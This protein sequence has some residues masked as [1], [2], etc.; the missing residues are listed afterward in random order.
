M[1]TVNL[2]VPMVLWGS[3]L[4][5]VSPLLSQTVHPPLKDVAILADVSQSVKPDVANGRYDEAREIIADLIN[6]IPFNADSYKAWQVDVSMASP[7]MRDLF[8]KYLTGEGKVQ[9]G[10]LSG[11]DHQLLMLYLGN[12]D[13]VNQSATAHPLGNGNIG[14]LLRES[15]PRRFED[16]STCFWY[17][18]ARAANALKLQAQ[19]GYYLFVISD[20]EDD[21]E[22]RSDGPESLVDPQNKEYKRYLRNVAPNQPVAAI[23]AEI[24]QYFKFD[25]Y[26]GRRAEL[27]HVREGFPQIPIGRIY[28]KGFRPKDEPDRIKITWYA[29]GV[30]PEAVAVAPVVA[31]APPPAPIGHPALLAHIDLLGG[32][33]AGNVSEKQFDYAEPLIVWQVTN[34]ESAGANFS[35]FQL[36]LVDGAQRKV[37]DSV[38]QR[39]LRLGGPKTAQAHLLPGKY[40]LQV[41]Q[42]LNGRPTDLKSSIFTIRVPSQNASWLPALSLVCIVA[43][44]GIFWGIWRSAR[45]SSKTVILTK[46]YPYV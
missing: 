31:V 8:G 41:V 43:A 21:P 38:A 35:E 2:A 33:S 5:A 36:Q 23:R 16:L 13:T 42:L 25:S 32:L 26:T 34:G 45:A 6:G 20:E 3:L 4:L 37:V 18:M 15:F 44:A 40:D 24:G 30:N 1:R 29:M 17:A 10:P 28:Q 7:Q 27:Y 12:L 19:E 46:T 22:Y 39:S 9:P 11:A 14:P